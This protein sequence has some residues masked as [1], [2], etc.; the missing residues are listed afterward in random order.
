MIVVRPPLRHPSCVCRTLFEVANLERSSQ[1]Q[2]EKCLDHLADA[3]RLAY[4]THQF[5]G[6]FNVDCIE[7][8]E[9]VKRLTQYYI[10]C[11]DPT[12][13]KEHKHAQRAGG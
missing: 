10:R 2:N 3:V 5:A 6:G 9:K 13:L 7:L 1:L 4:K 12:W 11:I 8:F